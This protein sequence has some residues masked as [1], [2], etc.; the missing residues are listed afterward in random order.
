MSHKK[1]TVPFLIVICTAALLL[2]LNLGLKGMAAANK[3]AD[4]KYVMSVLLPGSVEFTEELYEGEDRNIVAVYRGTG[5]Y[6]IETK[7]SGYVDDIVTLVGVDQEGAVTGLVVTNMSETFG[8][9]RRAMTDTA[10]L[11]QFLATKG[12]ADIGTNVD[13]LSGATVTSKAMVKAVNSAAAFVTGADVSS[14]ASEWGG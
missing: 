5:G 6:V 2:G 1:L 7:V 4:R 11:G 14:G 3:E 8:L 12:D 9:G 10:F 13:A